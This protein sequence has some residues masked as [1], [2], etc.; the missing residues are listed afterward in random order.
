MLDIDSW[1]PGWLTDYSL[2]LSL[3]HDSM[4][5]PK[6]RNFSKT[7]PPE[8]HLNGCHS[9]WLHFLCPTSQA[10]ASSSTGLAGWEPRYS[11]AADDALASSSCPACFPECLEVGTPKNIGSRK[12][13]GT[14]CCL[15]RGLSFG[16]RVLLRAA[17]ALFWDFLFSQ[18][19]Y[20]S[21]RYFKLYF[22]PYISWNLTLMVS[23]SQRCY[24]FKMC[25][26]NLW[27]LK[28]GIDSLL[29]DPCKCRRAP[30]I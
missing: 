29:Q 25:F 6:T 9:S 1:P 17:W 30:C 19:I 23:N 11:P 8:S 7:K 3:Q 12:G 10:Q 4:K 15:Y 18:W 26:G 22:L 2:S 5:D 13:S 20:L 27:F 24:L 16:L 14:Y 28:E 21:L